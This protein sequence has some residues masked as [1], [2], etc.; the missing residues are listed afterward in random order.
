MIDGTNPRQPRWLYGACP[1]AH[2][3]WPSIA[4]FRA[5]ILLVTRPVAAPERAR[6]WLPSYGP[7]ALVERNPKFRLA[8]KQTAIAVRAVETF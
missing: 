3:R 6:H 2:R 7:P 5:R 8:H 4:L 1:D